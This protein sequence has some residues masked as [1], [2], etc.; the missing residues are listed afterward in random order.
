[1]F[2]RHG[3]IYAVYACHS[4]LIEDAYLYVLVRIL[5]QRSKP[6][7]PIYKHHT[8]DTQCTHCTYPY[9]DIPMG[10]GYGYMVG[11]GVGV[12][13]DTHGYTHAIRY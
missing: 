5:V 13:L 6:I 9:P 4:E 10:S 2:G 3:D 12:C 7:I 1:M 8:H 11:M